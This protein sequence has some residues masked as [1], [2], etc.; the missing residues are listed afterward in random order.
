MYLTP[1]NFHY[2][3]SPDKHGA[4]KQNQRWSL[5][6][7]SKEK[8]SSLESVLGGERGVASMRKSI[9]ESGLYLQSQFT[10]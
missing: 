6:C 7:V 10:K 3:S 4:C 8:F 1:S 9:A 5:G 2:S